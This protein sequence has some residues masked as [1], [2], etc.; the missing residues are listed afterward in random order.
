MSN[1]SISK[2][3]ESVVS[4]PC[5]FQQNT[6]Q[7]CISLY[8]CKVLD[9]LVLQVLHPPTTGKLPK[10]L[11]SCPLACTPAYSHSQPHSH[12]IPCL[13]ARLLFYSLIL[14]LLFPVFTHSSNSYPF[15]GR[16]FCLYFYCLLPINV[17]MLH[18]PSPKQPIKGF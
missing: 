8:K 1:V 10:S 7:K 17:Q 6:F 12:P 2:I 11:A 14:I 9:D 15:L 13:L 3:F 4:F 5:Q 16:R 18:L